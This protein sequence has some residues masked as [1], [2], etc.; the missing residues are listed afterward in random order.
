MLAVRPGGSGPA[1]AHDL[2]SDGTEGTQADASWAV[3]A[4]YIGSVP[5]HRDIKVYTIMAK[6]QVWL[7]SSSVIM[8]AC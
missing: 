7:W 3:A 5:T 4:R 1:Q 2:G 6:A 8:V